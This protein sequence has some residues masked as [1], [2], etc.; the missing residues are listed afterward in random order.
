MID[1]ESRIDALLREAMRVDET[2]GE[3]LLLSVNHK[4]SKPLQFKAP[5]RVLRIALIAATLVA[6]L[7]TTALAF[8]GDILA[9]LSRKPVV[10]PVEFAEYYSRVIV[11]YDDSGDVRGSGVSLS[12]PD[13]LREIRNRSVPNI[14]WEWEYLESTPREEWPTV[15]FDSFE[16]LR[17]AA[18]FAVREPSYLPD[19]W[20][21]SQAELFL[22]EDGTYS[23]D[24]WVY[25]NPAGRADSSPNIFIGQYYVGPDAYF[26]IS[27]APEFE[28]YVFRATS[29][30][31]TVMVGDEEALLIV[32]VYEQDD[33]EGLRL[34]G[35]ELVWT[36]GDMGF[37]MYSQKYH[38]FGARTDLYP[39]SSEY[40]LDSMIETLIAIAGSL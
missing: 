31:E 21:F 22:Y 37:K 4:A 8:G 35:V 16:E 12:R 14:G 1:N 13:E 34:T 9:F 19:G 15:S 40:D 26:E 10:E 20:E 33:A 24:V 38:Y 11:T 2:P 23:Y 17:Q 32:N 27:L 18:P 36:H 25:Y 6:V 29:S 7:M 28:I 5:K 30:A 39:Y 3:E